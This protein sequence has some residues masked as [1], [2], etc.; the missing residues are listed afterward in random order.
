MARCKHGLDFDDCVACLSGPAP[1][2]I[3]PCIFLDTDGR[4]GVAMSAANR[5]GLSRVLVH[6]DSGLEITYLTVA[7]DDVARAKQ[8]SHHEI[9]DVLWDFVRAAAATGRFA[10]PTHALTHRER[11]GLQAPHCWKCRRVVGFKMQSMNCF[12]CN[13]YVCICGHCLCGFPGGMNYLEQFIPPQPPPPCPPAA[14]REFVR[15]VFFFLHQIELPED[16]TPKD[17]AG[18]RPG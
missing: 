6:R 14:R 11:I 18:A 7:P 2:A 8:R 17:S 3:P 12:S 1:D 5:E 13:C 15:L 10:A 4:Y 16:W 9:A